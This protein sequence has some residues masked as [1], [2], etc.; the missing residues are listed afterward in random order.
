[1]AKRTSQRLEAFEK[2]ERMSDKIK[3][4]TPKT[5]AIGLYTGCFYKSINKNELSKALGKVT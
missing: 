2:R 5:P 4:D 1:M 3:F